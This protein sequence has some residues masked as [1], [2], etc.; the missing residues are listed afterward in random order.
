MKIA[1][2]NNCVEVLSNSIAKL[3]FFIMDYKTKKHLDHSVLNLLA[4]R[5]NEAMSPSVFKKL[6]ECQRLLSGNAYIYIERDG[7]GKARRLI[8]L[9]PDNVTVKSENNF[10]Y[11]VFSDKTDRIGKETVI[12][13]ENIIHLKA[14]SEDGINGV[15]V[16]ERARQTIDTAGKHQ[17]YENNFYG[18]NARPSGILTI[19]SSLNQDAKEKV[20]KEWEKVYGGVDGMFRPAVLDMGLDYKPL[21]INQRDS[22]FIESKEISVQDICR[23]FG[24]PLYKVQA[25]KQSYSSNEQNSIEYVTNTIQPIV[26][27]YEEEFTYKLFTDSEI[28][29]GI[30]IKCNMNAELRGSYAARSQFYRSLR[31]IGALSANDIR[32]YEDL[33]EIDGGDEYLASLNYIPLSEFRELSIERNSNKNGGEN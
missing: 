32:A 3:P 13:G 21:G 5:P 19:Q 1:A 26:T 24:V 14:Y 8:P 29:R 11:Y 20:R 17:S 15:S 12:S 30:E 4:V 33:P 28:N 23:F 10:I 9:P 16:L 27:Q 7:F 18:K 6:I 31:E 22:Q 25:G 2:V